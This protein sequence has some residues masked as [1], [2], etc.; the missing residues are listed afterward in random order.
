LEIIAHTVPIR[1]DPA[2]VLRVL[3]QAV[4][5]VAVVKSKRGDAARSAERILDFFEK[6]CL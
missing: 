1:T 5:G 6:N 3:K 2:Y 4:K